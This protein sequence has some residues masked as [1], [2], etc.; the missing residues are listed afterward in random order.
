[1]LFVEL[2]ERE[3]WTVF[4]QIRAKDHDTL[5]AVL[6]RRHVRDLLAKEAGDQS[7]NGSM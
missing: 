4:S 3:D 2:L 7:L 5:P 6:T 1:M